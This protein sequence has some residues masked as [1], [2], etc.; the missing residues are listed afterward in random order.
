MDAVDEFYA[1]RL[2][3][4]WYRVRKI[5]A[6][7]LPPLLHEPDATTGGRVFTFTDPCNPWGS[8]TRLAIADLERM[9]CAAEAQ[10]RKPVAS[11]TAQDGV[12]VKTA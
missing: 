4:R 1:V 10:L 8:K 9:V 5:R 7:L 11:E 3:T 2:F 6:D 12:A